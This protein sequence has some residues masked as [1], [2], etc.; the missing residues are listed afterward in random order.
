MEITKKTSSLPEMNSHAKKEYL[1]KIKND[2]FFL[3]GK[4]FDLMDQIKLEEIH[5]EKKE[6]LDQ[7]AQS[8]Q[9]L[10]SYLSEVLELALIDNE[11]LSKHEEPTLLENEEKF[12]SQKHSKESK[13][14]LVEDHPIS[15][16]IEKEILLHLGCVVDIASNAKQALEL[17]N[18]EYYDLIFMDIGLPDMT[19]Y[20][21][22]QR[23]RSQDLT[24]ISHIPIVALTAHTDSDNQQ[25]CLDSKMNAMITKPFTTEQAEDILN[26]FI[27][28]RKK[29]IEMLTQSIDAKDDLAEKVVNFEYAKKLLNGNEKVAHEML[30]MLI[31]SLPQ[32]VKKITEAY[33]QNDWKTLNAI[34]HKLKGGSSYCGTLRLKAACTELEAY[35][36]SGLTTRI[37]E[38]YQKML[39]EIK[40][41][42]EFMKK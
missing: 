28:R 9:S 24:S 33:E 35:I 34:A 25:Q 37:P 15:A 26:T 23:I 20:E 5:S 16:K 17:V 32:E 30:T 10:F 22:T 13:I 41:L 18:K 6:K 3:I 12:E 29:T 1:S 8:A 11:K 2:A 39:D 19:G 31:D 4:I 38:L 21:V 27:P 14:L 7:V 42:Q 36:K 40:A